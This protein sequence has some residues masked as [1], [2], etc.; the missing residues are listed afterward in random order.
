MSKS[1]VTHQVRLNLTD[2]EVTLP[3][4]RVLPDGV[5]EIH[6]EATPIK[7]LEAIDQAVADEPDLDEQQRRELYGSIETAVFRTTATWFFLKRIVS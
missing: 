1:T 3:D 7:C 6:F 2:C 4:G 5:Y